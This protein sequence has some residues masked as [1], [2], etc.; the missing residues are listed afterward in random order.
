[1]TV[2]GIDPGPKASG[3]VIFDGTNVI[4]TSEAYENEALIGYLEQVPKEQ[5]VVIERVQFYGKL[6]GADVFDTLWFGG[7]FYQAVKTAGGVPHRVYWAEVKRQ[8]VE[9]ARWDEK[10][11]KKR[12]ITEADVRLGVLKRFGGE[13]LAKGT[14]AAPGPCRGVT[15]HAWS[16]LALALYW[17]D[18]ASSSG[19]V[20]PMVRSEAAL[21]KALQDIESLDF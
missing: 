5:P 8:F 12:K 3:F 17:W 2:I 1:M 18:R 20:S 4:E 9:G 16:A 14:K 10:K 15:S 6:M 13:K 19:I 7:R 11:G 21:M